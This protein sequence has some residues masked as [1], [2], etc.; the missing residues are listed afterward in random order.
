MLLFV[1]S[2]LLLCTSYMLC[3]ERVVGCFS[4]LEGCGADRTVRPAK[5]S[6]ITYL[7]DAGA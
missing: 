2:E 5:V 6:T 7:T 4:L 3:G 1:I